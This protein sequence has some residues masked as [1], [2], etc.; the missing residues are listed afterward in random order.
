MFDLSGNYF[1]SSNE[2]IID[3]SKFNSGVYYIKAIFD[4]H[5]FST[6]IIKL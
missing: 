3:V 6:K 5:V 4:N 2:N 1:L